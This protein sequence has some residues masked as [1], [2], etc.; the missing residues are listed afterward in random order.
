M[1]ELPIVG[2]ALSLDQFVEMRDV[3]FD[4][5]RDLE[6]QDFHN[7][8]TLDSDYSGLVDRA[9]AALEG[10]QGRHGIHGPFWDLPL[11]TWDPKIREVIHDRMFKALGICEALGSTHMVV[12]S[13]YLEWD[14]RNIMHYPNAK[15]GI[16]ERFQA[17]MAPV[18]KRAEEVGTTLVLENIAD[19]DPHFR[20]ELAAS[21]ASDALQISVDTGHAHYAHGVCGAPP[22]DYFVKAAGGRLQHVHLQ[23]ADGYADRHW[24]LGE[25]TIRWDAVFR[26]IGQL[27]SKP[28]LIIEVYGDQSVERSITYL[29]KAGL[30]Q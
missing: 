16:F 6:L 5:D 4:K 14:H 28:R 19:I 15:E 26:A 9:K 13:P 2:A 20:V 8:Q 3:M 10:Y 27:S 23:D 25:G 21:L 30:A 12:H 29:Q 11:A 22:V 1:S 17:T 18:V 7:P 24:A